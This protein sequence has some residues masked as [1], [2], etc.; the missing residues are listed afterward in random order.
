MPASQNTDIKAS[1]YSPNGQILAVY[2][3]PDDTHVTIPSANE[4]KYLKIEAISNV[5]MSSVFMTGQ[6]KITH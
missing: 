5:N 1:L 6:Y 3:N 2:E 4:L